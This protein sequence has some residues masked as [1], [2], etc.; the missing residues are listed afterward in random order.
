MAT[1][2]PVKHFITLPGFSIR[3]PGAILLG[4]F[5]LVGVV[6]L[7]ACAPQNPVR[8]AAQTS[9]TPLPT[10]MTPRAYMP[11][12][13]IPQAPTVTPTPVINRRVLFIQGDHIPESGYP[14]SRVAD[15]GSK[16]ESFTRLRHE[17]LEGNLNL[18]VDEFVLT[19]NNK[20]DAALLNP[21]GVVVLGSNGRTLAASEVTAL[22]TYY[23]NGGSI[24]TYADFQYGPNNWD[25]DNSFLKQYGVVVLADNFQPTVNITDIVTTHVVMTGVTAFRGEGISQF[26]VS[27]AS[28]TQNEVLARCS[29]LT[30]SGCIL[31][32]AD[33]PKV[34]KGDV[35]A[36][37]FVRVNAGGGRLA[38]VCDRNGFQNGPGPGS[39]IDQVDDRTFARNLFRWL[40][41]Q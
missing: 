14:H 26:I 31:P 7:S 21:Y 37:V 38:G 35:V 10:D 2:Q 19:D 3:P 18:I 15:D 22:K 41:R 11:A 13:A 20:I 17:V 8:L 39:D 27:A 29:P 1:G 36:C 30:R 9:I 4:A 34:K 25:S 12:V 5:W 6:I 23:D 40:S 33:L 24:L 28:L 32:A 16:P